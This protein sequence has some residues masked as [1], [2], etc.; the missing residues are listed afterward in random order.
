M[1]PAL[2]TVLSSPALAGLLRDEL[3]CAST[4]VARLPAG[5]LLLLQPYAATE[6][7]GS[8]PALE[9]LRLWRRIRVHVDSDT[10]G[11]DVR[12]AVGALPWPDEAFQC[13]VCQHATE[14]V[15]EPDALIAELARVL[16]PGGLLL[17]FGINPL[18]LCAL[19]CRWNA[20]TGT[21][22]P[23]WSRPGRARAALV[24]HALQPSAPRYIGS[25]RPTQRVAGNHGRH[26]VAHLRGAYLITARKRVATLTPRR[27]VA[28]RRAPIGTQLA[29]S[30]SQRACA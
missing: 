12:A 16:A 15:A 7:S 28:A 8:E 6:A 26:P 25:L 20:H 14:I 21:N 18:S 27:G 1:E 11:G 22:K 5:Q 2:D 4:C 29:G 13:I 9:E 17:G 30:A 24:R 3:A 23:H 10:V 19:W